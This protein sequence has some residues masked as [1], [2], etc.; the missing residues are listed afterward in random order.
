MGGLWLLRLLLDSVAES[1][2]VEINR[3]GLGLILAF[4]VA[5]GCIAG[6]ILTVKLSDS[7]GL[8]GGPLWAAVS[9]PFV[10]ALIAVGGI[11][12]AADPQWQRIVFYHFGISG[13]AAVALA[14]K[15]LLL[16]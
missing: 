15:S 3:V 10:A 8:F 1:A 2:S 14:A 9:I 13:I 16:D 11:I 5:A 7:T 12:N 6:L 4:G